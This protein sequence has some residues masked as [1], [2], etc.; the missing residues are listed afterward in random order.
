V[1]SHDINTMTG[2]A[3][4]RPARVESM[5]GLLLVHQEGV[6]LSKVIDDLL[7]MDDCSDE[8]ASLER[9]VSG[10]TAAAPL[11]SL[12]GRA[13]AGTWQRAT[14]PLLDRRTIALSFT[15]LRQGWPRLPEFQGS[16]CYKAHSGPPLPLS[17]LLIC[18][19]C[20]CLLSGR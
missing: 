19:R 7:L 9:A 6:A 20:R 5:A 13:D 18:L 16:T 17:L 14:L 10:P 2:F 8:V 1:L 3:R 11:R 12:V 15:E 4:A